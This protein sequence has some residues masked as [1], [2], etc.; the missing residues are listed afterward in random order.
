[1]L[2]VSGGAVVVVVAAAAN[3]VPNANANATMPANREAI[4]GAV[5]VAAENKKRCKY[6][7]V[8]GG[9]VQVKVST[10]PS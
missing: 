3:G 5:V 2:D 8:G 1:M 9:G 6:S 7:S 4:D 10:I